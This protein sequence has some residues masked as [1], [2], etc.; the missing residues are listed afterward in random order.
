MGALGVNELMKR[1]LL[2]L[3][4]TY[5]TKDGRISQ[6]FQETTSDGVHFQ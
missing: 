5:F 2:Y 3:Y 1:I 6:N 4:L